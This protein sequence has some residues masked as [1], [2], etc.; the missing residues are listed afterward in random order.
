LNKLVIHLDNVI[1]TKG[2]YY[3]AVGCL[4]SFFCVL[5]EDGERTWDGGR[6]MDGGLERVGGEEGGRGE[7]AGWRARRDIILDKARSSLQDA[8]LFG[9]GHRREF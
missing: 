2:Q 3:N 5:P 8:I 6:V 1:A 7:R 4:D 9:W